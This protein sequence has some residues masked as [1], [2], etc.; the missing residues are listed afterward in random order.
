MRTSEAALVAMRSRSGRSLD[1]FCTL[2]SV[3]RDCGTTVPGEAEVRRRFDRIDRVDVSALAADAFV[4]AGSHHGLASLAV[5]IPGRSVSLRQAWPQVG[6]AV[7]RAVTAH[8]DRVDADLIVLRDWAEATVAAASGI[9][10]LLTTW[11]RAVDKVGEPLVCGV[12]AHG[13]AEAIR[14]GV[15]SPSLLA[16][17][18]AARVTL[19][20]P[21][22]DATDDG[23]A[24]MLRV[25]VTATD[26]LAGGAPQAPP[27]NGSGYLAL[28]GDE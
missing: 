20:D 27:D 22:A 11:Y 17:D 5:S 16:D 18:I 25:L 9:E 19:F 13:A 10:Q 12:P 21:A 8:G 1:S 23:I 28:A 4:L 24:E 2:L 15:V 14:T 7:G 26:D 6:D 3:G